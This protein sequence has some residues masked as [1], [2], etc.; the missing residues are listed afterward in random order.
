[1]PSKEVAGK[2]TAGKEMAGK[3]SASKEIASKE[4]A[5]INFFFESYYGRQVSQ[6]FTN[7]LIKDI[8]SKERTG[9]EIERKKLTSK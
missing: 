4:I 5:G 9:K 8:L 7:L 2:E 3:E 1:M 6:Y